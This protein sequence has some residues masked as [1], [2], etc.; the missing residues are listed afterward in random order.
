M[1]FLMESSTGSLLP[2]SISVECAVGV[3][4]ELIMLEIVICSEGVAS[5]EVGR[6][7]SM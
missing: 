6:I 1:A 5:G 3:S 2:D 4:S 7:V